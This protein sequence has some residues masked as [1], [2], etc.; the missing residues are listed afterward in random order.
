MFVPISTVL[1]RFISEVS[2]GEVDNFLLIS[3]VFDIFFANFAIIKKF[4][5]K[6]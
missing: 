2:H 5:P 4:L 1:I 6:I 3:D